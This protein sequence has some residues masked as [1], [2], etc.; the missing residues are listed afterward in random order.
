MDQ[1][2]SVLTIEVEFYVELVRNTS[3]SPWVVHVAYLV[4]VTSLQCLL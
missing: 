2:H 3:A 1:T 4:T